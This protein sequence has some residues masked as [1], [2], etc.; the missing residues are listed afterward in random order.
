MDR[1]GWRIAIEI[2]EGHLAQPQCS[3]GLPGQVCANRFVH[4]R[5]E[6]LQHAMGIQQEDAHVMVVALIISQPGLQLGLQLD[7]RWIF[8]VL[9][10]Q[11][12]K[13][14]VKGEHICIAQPFGTPAFK[15]VY[16]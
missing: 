15:L 1:S 5:S 14:W 16:F 9:L 7:I 4:G 6:N 13:G 12:G 8:I 10:H 11:Q 3:A 2:H